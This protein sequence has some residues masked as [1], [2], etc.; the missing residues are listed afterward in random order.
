MARLLVLP[1]IDEKGAAGLSQKKKMTIKAAVAQLFD[2]GVY[3]F[4]VTRTISSAY[5]TK[6]VPD[7]L[8][9][10]PRRTTL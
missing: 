5:T 1:N 9:P 7:E 3:K 4:T 10:S 2:I 8:T 6:V